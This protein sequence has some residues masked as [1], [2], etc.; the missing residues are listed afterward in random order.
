M[1]YTFAKAMGGHI[2]QSI[3][4]DYKLQLASTSWPKPRPG[5]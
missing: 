4:E 2:G 5:R 1:T 3:C